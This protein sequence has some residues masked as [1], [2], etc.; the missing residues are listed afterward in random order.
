MHRP[1]T[2]SSISTAPSGCIPSSKPRPV[3]R[4]RSV[5][6]RARLMSRTLLH[7]RSTRTAS[8]GHEYGCWTAERQL[9]QS[10]GFACG[11]MVRDHIVYWRSLRMMSAA[12]GYIVFLLRRALQ[13]KG[14]LLRDKQLAAQATAATPATSALMRRFLRKERPPRAAS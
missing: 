2:I 4:Q 8:R 11:Q 12:R 1:Q 9:K 5:S 6:E 3:H 10:C 13:A 7:R 14:A